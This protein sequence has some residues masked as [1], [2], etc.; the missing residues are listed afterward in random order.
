METAGSHLPGHGVGLARLAPDLGAQAVADLLDVRP[1]EL[2]GA[3]VRGGH[4]VAVAVGVGRVPEPGVEV[5]PASGVAP[6]GRA[7]SVVTP[8]ERGDCQLSG[9][10]VS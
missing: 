9:A 4:A 6:P 10:I 3:P 5:V 2:G 8:V 7:S 1:V